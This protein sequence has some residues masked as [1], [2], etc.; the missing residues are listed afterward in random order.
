MAA[1]SAAPSRRQTTD[2]VPGEVGIWV[3]VLGD[4]TVFGL[5]FAAY[6]VYRAQSFE[7]YV[8]SQ[9][10]LDRTYGLINTLL[11]LTSSC[12]VALGVGR[13]RQ[14]QNRS[15]ARLFA[16]ALCCGVGFSLVKCLEYSA[17]LNA[18]IT[19]NSNE[20]Y[21]FYYMLT[22]LHFL[23]VIIGMLVLAFLIGRTRRGFSAEADL[24]VLE[25]G[26][27]YWHM[28]DLLWIVI[29]PLLYLMH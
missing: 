7:L 11:L 2:H 17:K 24:S 22:G 16:L 25:S 29:F 4:M 1:P 5:L 15:A 8:H 10:T 23:H 27:T 28:V 14:A 12:F 21:A 9:A 6:I 3:F 26:A 18:G 20:F 19:L 13:A